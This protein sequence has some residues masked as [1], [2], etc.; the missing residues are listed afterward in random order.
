M[1]ANG[2]AM[3]LGG[4]AP[5]FLRCMFSYNGSGS[6][7][8]AV[9]AY[10]IVALWLDCSFIS[11]GCGDSG[12]GLDGGAGA[13]EPAGFVGVMINCDFIDNYA[14][15]LGG[16]LYGSGTLINCRFIDNFSSFEGGAG[17]KGGGTLINCEFRRNVCG[18]SSF[19]A[20]G[21]GAWITADSTLTNCLFNANDSWGWG[22]AA[23]VGPGVDASFANC[24]F[25]NNIT[26]GD[27]GGAISGSGVLSNCVLWDNSPAELDGDFPVRYS[28]V[29]GG[30]PGDGNIAQD[31][32][33]IDPLG[34]DA[35]AGT[36]DDNLRLAHTSP[37][38]DAADNLALPADLFD[39][40][41]DGDIGER[42]PIDLDAKDRFVNYHCA[43]DTG[44]S[45]G[46]NF[47]ADMGPY[48]FAPSGS[49]AADLTCDQQV[50][51]DDLLALINP[52]GQ[53]PSVPQ[54]CPADLDRDGTVDV[55]DLLILLQNWG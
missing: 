50:N 45:D 8:G 2:G 5:T 30:W 13:G 32:Q 51:V 7:G 19:K 12:G 21:A 9:L 6:R 44:N 16:G 22:G 24:T 31:P 36:A 27:E 3:I 52:W 25:A 47:P 1:G 35:A 10:D 26:T 48:E 41:K 20:G 42:I 29:K 54:P 49:V 43:P 46:V 33:F 4:G 28:C 55:V 37:C 15:Q 14:S 18:G 39:L 23:Y 17:L 53:C 40:D 38:I 34:P 11:N